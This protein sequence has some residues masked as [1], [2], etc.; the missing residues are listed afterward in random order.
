MRSTVGIAAFSAALLFGVLAAG[1]NWAQPAPPPPVDFN[2][3]IKPLFQARC[4]ACHGPSLQ[5]AGLRLDSREAAMKGSAAGPVIV[6]GD[7]G[8]SKLYTMVAS[9]RMPIDEELS[10][11]ELDNLR[12]WINGGA[13]WPEPRVMPNMVVDPKIEAWRLAVRNSDRPATARLLSDPA[14][15]KARGRNGATALHY[16]VLYGDLRQVRAVL[17]KGADVNAADLDGVT[18]LI[19]AVA[20]DA[21]ARLLVERGA[22]VNAASESGVTPLIAAAGRASGADLVGYLVDKGAKPT[23]AQRGPLTASA[24]GIAN[25]QTLK[26]LFPRVLDPMG[27]SGEQAAADAIAHRCSACLDYILSLGVKG[28]RLG[29]ALVFAANSGDAALVKRL[30]A[31]GATLDG[32]GTQGATAL[33]AA[34][35]SDTDAVEKARLLLEAG[36][37]PNMPAAD[38]RTPVVYARMRHPEIVPMLIAKGA[39]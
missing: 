29:T 4:V 22:D 12:N 36:A 31:L 30:L 5:R 27:P 9:K 10:V 33:I 25:P 13:R 38:G 2:A 20:D 1:S 39:K 19:W 17:D 6:P 7:A 34:S 8:N 3:G 23:P 28:P 24:S 15:A 32:R 18:P 37:D 14:L 11:L 21:K 16:A 35:T 26:V